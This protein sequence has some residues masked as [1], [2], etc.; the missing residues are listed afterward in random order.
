VKIAI[1][2]LGYVGTVCGAC[3]AG[4]GHEVV[5]VDVSTHKVEMINSGKSPI[6]ETGL[7]ELLADVSSRGLFRGSTDTSAVVQQSDLSLV[8]V[9]TPSKPDGSLN[10][11]FIYTVCREIGQALRN[12]DEFHLVVLRST[13]LPGTAEACSKI[14]EEESGKKAGEGF[15]VASNP[16]FLREGSAIKDFSFPAFT[17]VGTDDPRG[18]ELL[19]E[20]Y[21]HVDAP[22]HAVPVR[23]A[24]MLKYACNTFHALKVVFGNEIG[25]VA[26]ALGADSHEVM[27]LFCRDTRL[28]ISPT[29]LR[30]GYAY[31]GSCLPKDLRALTAAASALG[32][33]TP[34]LESISASNDAHV[35]NGVDLVVKTG[36]K[37]VGL[38]GLSFK[39]GTD[40]LRESPLV[41]LAERLLAHGLDLKIFD[42]SV[43]LARLV[44]ANKAFIDKQLPH[45]SGLLV[46]DMDEVLAHAECVV[47]GNPDKEFRG[48]T[49]KLRPDQVMVDLVRVVPGLRSGGNYKGICW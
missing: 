5:G 41:Q 29:Y 36:C 35:G 15:A 34:V 22:F 12:R 38:L 9:G 26:K 6:V 46:D 24:E 19:R 16:E 3:F 2:G 8:C 14:V 47:I 17:I 43:N 48:V 37:R 30:P 39:A 25:V 32:I 45:L 20:L 44:G 18:E 10:L 40:D 13:M 23:V 28:N 49:E 42:R 31:G 33:A 1:L 11:D 4:A 27:D 21:A 7:D